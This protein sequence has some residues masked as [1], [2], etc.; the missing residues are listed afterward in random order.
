MTELGFKLWYSNFR[1]SHNVYTLCCLWLV[2]LSSHIF[3]LYCR[4]LR[5]LPKL[6]EFET[7]YWIG[8][9]YHCY[10]CNFWD[11]CCLPKTDLMYLF[12]LPLWHIIICPSEYWHISFL[13]E[14]ITVSIGRLDLVVCD[15]RKTKEIF[16]GRVNS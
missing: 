8:M 1:S 16:T 15:L 7:V 11:S 9:Y 2:L 13:G 3:S 14:R 4:S 10:F 6:L 5:I 12:S